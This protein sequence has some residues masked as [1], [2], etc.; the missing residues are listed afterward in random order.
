MHVGV[1]RG[2]K[3]GG[4]VPSLR[5]GA[6][7]FGR[8]TFNSGCLMFELEISSKTLLGDVFEIANSSKVREGGTFNSG[9]VPAIRGGVPLSRGG[10]FNSGS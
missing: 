1:Q 6:L 2:Q 9:G 3:F 10:T 5:G 4:G 8:G 7:Q